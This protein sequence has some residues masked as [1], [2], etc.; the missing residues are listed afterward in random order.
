[1]LKVITQTI[2]KEAIFVQHSTIFTKPQIHWTDVS[3]SVFGCEILHAM[4]SVLSNL[5]ISIFMLFYV[6]ETSGIY[7]I[8]QTHQTQV[9]SYEELITVYS[10]V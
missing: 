1:M 5:N 4:L 8:I 2:Y 7:N 10:R 6:F 3:Y 9:F